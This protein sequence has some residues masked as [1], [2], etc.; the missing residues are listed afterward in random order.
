M[1]ITQF[2]E[3]QVQGISIRTK[4][5]NEMN[6][7]TAKIRKLHQHFDE[8][9]SIDYKAGARV[10]GVYYNYESDANGEFSV[11][12]GADSVASSAIE[13][14]TIT[15]TS[16]KYM[17]FEGKGEMPQAIINAWGEI[18]TY[19]SDENISNSSHQR[20]YTTDFEY[21]LSENEFEIYISVK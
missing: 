3:K 19:F 1:K 17:V 16:G 7:S 11:L 8:S 4:N 15:L 9:V 13:L 10:Y 21:Y 12:S 2:N 6:P 5:T 14:E 18:W 20:A